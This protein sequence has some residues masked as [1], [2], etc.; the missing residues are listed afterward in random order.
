[1]KS[2]RRPLT[3]TWYEVWDRAYWRRYLGWLGPIGFWMQ[4]FGARHADLVFADS[5]LTAT[6]LTSWL[7]V[8]PGKVIVRERG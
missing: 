8:D 3:A 6:R 1:M 5:A 7:G 4:R 2:C